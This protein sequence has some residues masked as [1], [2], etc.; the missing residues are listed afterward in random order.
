MNGDIKMDNE[1]LLKK[2]KNRPSYPFETIAVAIAFSPRLEAVLSEATRLSQ[3]LHSKLVL[4]HVGDKTSVKEEYLDSL[5][6]KLNINPNQLRIIW[7]E[8]DPIDTILKLCKLNVVDLLVLGALEKESLYRYYVGSIARKISR[9]AKCSVLLITQPSTISNKPRK[10][11]VSGE[12][13]PKTIHSLNTALYIASNYNVKEITLIKEINTKEESHR[14]NINLRENELQKL[15]K[16]AAKCERNNVIIHERVIEGKPG[17]SIA[18]YTRIQKADMLVINSPDKQLNF[19]D[20]IFTK[21][22]EHILADL[23][24]SLLIVHSRV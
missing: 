13:N 10:I 6:A 17:L 20:R 22:I 12:D 23:P 7:T 16:L 3:Q 2:L 18:N 1:N 5:T 24:S 19:L 8:G 21:E 14:E 15:H 9:N 4:I 11:M